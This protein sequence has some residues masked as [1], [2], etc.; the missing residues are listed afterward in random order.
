MQVGPVFFAKS[1]AGLPQAAFE[2]TR[3]QRQTVGRASPAP[4]A[5]KRVSSKT[6]SPAEQPCGPQGSQQEV[7]TVSKVTDWPFPGPGPPSPPPPN[8]AQGQSCPPA[9]A[10]ILENSRQV[11]QRPS[12]QPYLRPS[13]QHWAPFRHWSSYF[14]VSACPLTIRMTPRTGTRISPTSEW[15]HGGPGSLSD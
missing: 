11:C 4:M 7:N 13:A 2:S 3:T 12:A 5:A 15:S 14:Y 6:S 9:P 1:P 8:P 10:L